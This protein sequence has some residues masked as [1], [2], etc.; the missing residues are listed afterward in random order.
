MDIAFVISKGTPK[1]LIDYI[2]AKEKEMRIDEVYMI[3][4]KAKQ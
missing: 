2:F 1:E 4:S 3:A